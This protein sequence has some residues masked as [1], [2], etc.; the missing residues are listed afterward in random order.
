MSQFFIHRPVLSIVISLVIII[1]GGL[2]IGALPVAQYP[3]IAPPTVV[4]E[5]TYPGANAQ[6]VEESVAIPIE[7]EV[8]GAENMIYMSSKSMSD[9]RYQLTCTFEVGVDLDIAAVQVQNRVSKAQARLPVEV[10]N[11]GVSVKKQSPDMLMV[12]SIY[13]PDDSY[14]ALY[15]SNY[16]SINVLDPLTRVRGV[17]S[18]MLV[19]QRDYSMRIWLRPDKLAKLGLT[20]SDIAN[21]IREQNVQAPA[22]QIGA[23]PAAPGTEFQFTVNIQGRLSD[24]EEYANVIVRTLSDGS[25]LRLR[26]VAR[27]ELGAQDY[28]T[29]GRLNGKNATVIMVYQL[30][31]ANAMDVAEGIH[32]TLDQLSQNFPPG[33]A[34][35]VNI[36]MT[37][38]IDASIQEVMTTLFQALALVLLVVFVFLGSFRTTLIPM[39]AVPVSLIGAFAFFVPLGFS[40]NTLSLFGIVLAI[41]IVVDDAIVVVEAVEGHMASGLDPMKATERAMSEVTGPVIATT[42][43]LISVFVPVAFMGGIVG[44]LY[45]QFALTISVSVAISSVVALTL[46]PALCGLLLKPDDRV[47]GPIGKLI[48]AFNRVFDKVSRGYMK[49]VNRFIQRAAIAILIVIAVIAGAWGMLQVLPTGFV[50]MEDMGYF[51]AQIVLP[52]G[53]SLQ[54]TDAVARRAEKVLGAL[55]GVAS[56]VTLGGFSFIDGAINSNNTSFVVVLDNWSERGSPETK[57]DAI[58]GQ[59]VTELNKFPEALGLAFTSPPIPGLGNAGGF[60]FVL[61]DRAGGTID[62]LDQQARQ[63]SFAAAERGELT[64]I[65]NTFRASIP[66]LFIDL[67]RDKTKTLG[68]PVNMVFESLQTYLGGLLVNDFN[69]FGRAYKVK[70][71]AE[72]QFRLKPENIGSIYVRSA[73][74]AMVPLATLTEIRD[75]TGPDTVLRYNLYRA[76]KINGNAAPGYSSGQAIQAMEQVARANSAMGFGFEWTGTAF[77]E[78]KAGGE[79]GI[80][81]I[82]AFVFVFLVLAAKYESWAIPFGVI[83]GIPVGVLGAFLAVWGAGLINDVY[84]QIGL[85][86]LIGLVAKNAILIVEFAKLQRDQGAAPEEAASEAA[87]LRFRPILMTAISFIFGVMPLVLASG[88]GAASRQSLGWAVLGGMT[89]ATIVGVFL[90]PSLY[91]LIERVVIRVSGNREVTVPLPA[92]SELPG[93]EG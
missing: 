61:Q 6:A 14:D 31:T 90:V 70:L 86:V 10:N 22:G 75:S 71:Q 34:Y 24:P 8:N 64:G 35:A 7:Q 43:V 63:V 69:L 25:I 80:I 76:A 56:V 66:Q 68:I 17:G 39:L 88:A 60:E 83:L 50:P 77:Q 46:T 78:I 58:L 91:V 62:A 38:F 93:G 21:S 20:A 4:V 28:N 48:D 92:D 59:A 45:R 73:D 33:I 9:G 37:D 65:Y 2:A 89:L 18:T 29:I 84:V 30:P 32:D 47:R 53:A 74:G 81:L 42:L 19:G 52:D 57:V 67:D 3:Q 41:G 1:A 40:I 49:I 15:L 12:I 5:A 11:F 55:P 82:L 26:D 13:S 72:P 85:I 16:T 87:R 79:Q 23:P 27:S 44:Q 51:F 54:R 36:D